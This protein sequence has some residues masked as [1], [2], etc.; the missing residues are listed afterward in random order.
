[1]NGAKLRMKDLMLRSLYIVTAML[2]AI[3]IT[4]CSDIR[5]NGCKKIFDSSCKDMFVSKNEKLL[6]KKLDFNKSKNLDFIDVY[7]LI[8]ND[9]QKICVQRP[10]E[11]K[12]GFEKKSAIS[13]KDYEILSDETRNNLWLFYENGKQEI[14]SISRADI[15]DFY[16]SATKV[17]RIEC[18]DQ[19]QLIYY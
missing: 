6:I 15:Y 8:G 19:S 12:L 9:I 16:E 4:A 1:M 13:V 7:E 11:L 5:E 2:F 3:L 10:Y 18:G 17:N 14:L